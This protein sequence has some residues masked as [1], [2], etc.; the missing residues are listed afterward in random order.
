MEQMWKNNIALWGGEMFKHI[1]PKKYR[2]I[3]MTHNR[4]IKNIK[5]KPNLVIKKADKGNS[6]VQERTNLKES[7]T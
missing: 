6:I 1:S 7:T 3:E 2:W 4:N 5:Q